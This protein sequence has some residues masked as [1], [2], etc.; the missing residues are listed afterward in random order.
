MYTFDEYL[1]FK[2]NQK[3]KDK[4]ASLHII[5]ITSRHARG[6]VNKKQRDQGTEK[7][8]TN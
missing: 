6:Q 7:R 4:T 5:M 1:T 3:I 2:K 8:Q